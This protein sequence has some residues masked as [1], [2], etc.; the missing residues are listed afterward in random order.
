MAKT[1]SEVGFPGELSRL[2][3]YK[4]NQGRM[5]RQLTALGLAA[6]A[7]LGA[8]TMSQGWLSVYN[9]PVRVGVPVLISLIAVWIIFRAVNYA[10][11][12][13]FL[14]SVEA[15]MDKVSWATKTELYRATVVVI[16]TMFFLGAVLYAYDLLWN[17]ILTALRVLQI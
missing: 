15:E 8:Y 17:R 4:P 9:P 6:V 16:G 11:S 14:I 3:L 10:P 5:T 12:A 13:D 2:S 1:K 7:F